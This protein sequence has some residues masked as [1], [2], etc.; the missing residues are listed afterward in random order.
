[1]REYWKPIPGYAPYEASNL[2]RIRSNGYVT[3]VRLGQT[4]TYFKNTVL[5]P[6]PSKNGLMTVTVGGRVAIHVHVLVALAF[7]GPRPYGHITVHLDRNKTNNRPGNLA[8]VTRDKAAH[9]FVSKLT[10]EDVRKIRRAW[11]PRPTQKDLAR[12]FGVSKGHIGHIVG[13]LSWSCQ[14]KRKERVTVEV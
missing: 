7:K 9:L 2:G 5:Q 6:S 11:L 1:M 8:Y 14:P 10:P 12:Q 13:R 3:R 4:Q